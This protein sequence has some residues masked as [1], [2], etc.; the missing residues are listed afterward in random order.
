MT[1][2][3][4]NPRPI[5]DEHASVTLGDLA[6]LVAG[7]A[8]VLVLPRTQSYWP[9]PTDFLGPWPRW[10]PWFFCLRQFLGA[11]CMALVP[12]VLWRRG[13]YGGLARPA[14][15]LLLCAAAPFLANAIE[16]GLIRLSYRRWSGQTLPGFGLDGISTRF[17]D[18]WSNRSHWVWTQTLLIA[19]ATALAIFFSVGGGYPDGS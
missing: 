14:E 17:T 19:G 15:F 5:R 3:P 11:A 16:T 1:G 6:A 12:V 18:D 2:T 8:V 7:I 13:H 10:L 9:Y 4:T